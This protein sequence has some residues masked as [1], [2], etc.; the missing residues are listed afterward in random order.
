M[1]VS[2]CLRGSSRASLSLISRSIRF[3]DGCS[4]KNSRGRCHPRSRDPLSPVAPLFLPSRCCC[5]LASCHRLLPILSREKKKRKGK[6]LS[7]ATKATSVTS[8]N[9][10]FYRSGIKRSIVRT[11]IINFGF[12]AF[13]EQG[14]NRDRYQRDEF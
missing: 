2:R 8:R 12:Y 4:L 5:S 9:G 3:E 10:T 13:R 14:W 11:I 6:M 1:I 7:S